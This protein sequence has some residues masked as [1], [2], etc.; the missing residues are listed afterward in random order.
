MWIA[1]QRIAFLPPFFMHLLRL[2]SNVISKWI[3]KVLIKAVGY[4]LATT[5]SADIAAF[6]ITTLA[7]KTTAPYVSQ[8]ILKF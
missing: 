7:D 8:I 4:E 1:I 3:G 5:T 2:R 6:R